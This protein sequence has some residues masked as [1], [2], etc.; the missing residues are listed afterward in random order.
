MLK[1]PE[2]PF[3]A[4][5]VPLPMSHP[6]FRM[7]PLYVIDDTGLYPPQT[8]E[9]DGLLAFQLKE[10]VPRDVAEPNV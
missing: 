7:F 3:D 1:L 2:P 4:L 5:Q 8:V 10:V 9:G 6:S